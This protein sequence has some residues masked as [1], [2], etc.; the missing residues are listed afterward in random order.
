MSRLSLPILQCVLRSAQ[1][2]VFGKLKKK[3]EKLVNKYGHCGAFISELEDLIHFIPN[4]KLTELV[5]D[6]VK[7]TKEASDD[8]EFI[9]ENLSNLLPRD[10]KQWEDVLDY[11]KKLNIIVK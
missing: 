1:I 11:C 4:D 9:K 2:E 7:W 8:S 10:E 5:T 3:H 6:F